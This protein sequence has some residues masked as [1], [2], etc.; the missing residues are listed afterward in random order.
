MTQKEQW[1][2][3]YSLALEYY[4]E[5]GDLNVPQSYKTKNE[6]IK[7]GSWIANQRYAYNN[8]KLKKERIEKLEQIG[9]LWS[10]L[11]STRKSYETKWNEMYAQALKYLGENDNVNIPVNYKYED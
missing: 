3:M 7:L 11:E 4:K 1:N 9:M 8:G 6:G 5:Y 2:K 10:A